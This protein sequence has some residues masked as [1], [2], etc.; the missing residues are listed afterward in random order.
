VGIFF[1]PGSHVG[2]PINLRGGRVGAGVDVIEI[3]ADVMRLDKKRFRWTVAEDWEVCLDDIVLE[4]VEKSSPKQE[5]GVDA[6]P[7]AHSVVGIKADESLDLDEDT[8]NEILRT[9]TKDC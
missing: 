7:F 1:G 3:T 8:Q 6:Y 9:L 5:G 4:I 2:F